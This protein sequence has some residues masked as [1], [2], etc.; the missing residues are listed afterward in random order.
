[1]KFSDRRIAQKL[2]IIDSFDQKLKIV[3]ILRKD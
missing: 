3:D 1:M 2:A